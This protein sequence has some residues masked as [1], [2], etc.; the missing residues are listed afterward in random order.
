MF[1]GG[2]P[3]VSQ[4]EWTKYDDK[5]LQAV[6][7][8]NTEK[9]KHA[10]TK[11]GTSPSKANKE[12][13]TALHVAASYGEFSSLEIML[14]LGANIQLRDNEG[15][16]ALHLACKGG[17]LDSVTRLVQAGTALDVKDNNGKTVLHHSATGGHVDC[18]VLLM[19]AKATND[20]RDENQKTPLLCAAEEGH[21]EVCKELIDR[22]AAVNTVDEE[23]NSPL[24]IACKNQHQSV[25]DLLVKR[26]A[27]VDAE[28]VHG[29]NAAF[30]AREID[31]QAILSSLES[32]PPVATWDIRSEEENANEVKPDG[33]D[34]VDAF[35]SS[36]EDEADNVDSSRREEKEAPS[37]AIS[38]PTLTAA[39]IDNDNEKVLHEL[40]EENEMLNDE[41]QQLQV[42]NRKQ[43]DKVKQLE[44]Q[45]Q[46]NDVAVLKAQLEEEKEKVKKAT[47]EVEKMKAEAVSRIPKMQDTDDEITERT[48]RDS[49]GDSDVE[50]LFDLPALGS[51]N[52]TS[53]F[54]KSSSKVTSH[55]LEMISKLKKEN[56]ELEAKLKMS[57]SAK[58]SD[59]E[60]QLEEM[61]KR[62]EGK[63]SE[64]SEDDQ[65][66]K[67]DKET[68]LQAVTSH[69]RDKV[70]SLS[71][72]LAEVTSENEELKKQER[73]PTFEPSSSSPR[74]INL[75]RDKASLE[76]KL[77]EYQVLAEEQKQQ[78]DKL[79]DSLIKPN[80]EETTEQNGNQSLKDKLDE[81]SKENA[82]LQTMVG[83]QSKA[84][85]QQTDQRRKD[86]QKYAE[87]LKEK[88]ILEEQ[89]KGHKVEGGPG[90]LDSVALIKEC[91]ELKEMVKAQEDKLSAQEV[92]REQLERLQ[93]ENYQLQE[94]LQNHGQDNLKHNLIMTEQLSAEIEQVKVENAKLNSQLDRQERF[95]K[96]HSEND[97]EFADL[98]VTNKALED[99]VQSMN[100]E[101]ALLRDAQ[102]SFS[103]KRY[104]EVLLENRKLKESL[105]ND[106][107]LPNGEVKHSLNDGAIAKAEIERL[108]EKLTRTERKLDD[109]VTVYRQHLLSAVQ[110]N[111]DPAIKKALMQIVKLR[112]TNGGSG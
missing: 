8:G 37:R 112:S 66:I 52:S 75:L 107:A 61:R 13:Q 11:K 34:Y 68:S 40:E 109:T 89:V 18:T 86:K 39:N 110:G 82:R 38:M 22:G 99:K 30:Y 14:A 62:V 1:C 51:S 67:A 44:T 50:D 49:W 32:A 72:N 81:V 93:T 88:E 64:T 103:K 111:M 36:G 90:E 71:S 83:K 29:H 59:L 15:M 48:G 84:I 47:Q 25:V 91:R 98:S 33:V 101:L 69:L 76:K 56:K 63:E 57:E 41:V 46:A 70:S 7:D 87:L 31:D 21:A 104:T 100:E 85:A 5:V 4:N 20:I 58:I 60:G 77:K 94:Q 12:G 23:L 6:R 65:K 74:F 79:H 9:L 42:T 78:I 95:L 10:L 43:S 3:R 16:T 96:T 53:V 45:L 106:Q 2:W 54:Q 17:H 92:E 27:K 55:D 80:P 26:G 102:T 24:I 97:K 28:D 19:Q 35:S 105:Q 73:V 108:R